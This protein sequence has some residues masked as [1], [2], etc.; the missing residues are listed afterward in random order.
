MA[1]MSITFNGFNEL[2]EK[3]EQR[4]GFA[5]LKKAVNEALNETYRY[6]QAETSKATKPYESKSASHPYAT[7]AMYKS[8]KSDSTI[9]WEGNT[10]MVGVGYDFGKKGGYHSIF[11]MYG[12]PA[13]APKQDR[14]IYNAIRGSKT[15]KK[16]AEIQSSIMRK[17]LEL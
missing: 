12:T 2:A 4:L 11:V 1:K 15:K 17:Y 16:V 13:N 5:N 14:T 8:I 6:I 7:G 10:A 3:I 9:K